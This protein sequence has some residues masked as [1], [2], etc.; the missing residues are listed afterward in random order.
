MDDGYYDMYSAVHSYVK[1]K[2]FPMTFYVIGSTAYA[3]DTDRL[4]LAQLQ[5]MYDYGHAICNHAYNHTDQGVLGD[6]AYVADKVAMAN[7][8][9]ARGFT[10]KG[11][12]YHHAYVAGV[13]AASTVAAMQANGFLT[14]RTIAASR[15]MPTWNG[16]GNALCLDGG[17][18]LNNTLT[19]AQA[20]A[21]VD[22]AIQSG[23]TLVITGHRIQSSA[24]SI[25]WA[26]VDFQALVDYIAAY[27][28]AGQCNIQTVVDWYAGLTG[29]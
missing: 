26:T 9:A 18:Q 21:K 22:A 1:S 19:L 16:V 23:G 5:E 3:A 14:A 12:N 11:M 15:H 27:R 28:D 29:R 17:L 13:Y 10:R 20:K 8:L 24:G 25:H 2:N 7:W 6:A 4:T